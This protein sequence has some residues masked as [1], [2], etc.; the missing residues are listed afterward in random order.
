MTISCNAKR[1]IITG[2]SG[3]VGA[4]LARRLVHDGHEVHLFVRKG[5]TPWRIDALRAEARFTEVDLSDADGLIRVVADIR[6]DWVFHLAAYGAYPDQ[7]DL[8]RMVDTNIVGTMNLVAACLKTGF[9][10]FIN[11][12]SSSEYGFKTHAPSETEWLEPNSHYAVTKASATVFCSYTAQRYGVQLPTLRLYSVY[13]P[14]EEPT[15]LIPTIIVKGLRGELPPLTNPD[16][17][18]DYVYVEDVIDAFLLAAT[19][20]IREPGAVYNVGTGIQTSLREVVD[21]AR[22]AMGITAE[23]QWGTM[24]NR[25]WD[26]SIWVADN[27]KIQAELGWRPHHSFEHAFQMTADWFRDTPGLR[28]FY[29]HRSY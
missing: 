24:A 25:S 10:A 23:P 6:P 19:Q 3:F 18:R 9:Q 28:D 16:I 7:T 29:E 14:Y 26:T 11:T 2:G 5:Y 27:R 17:A 20:A 22:S 1:V 12:G 4:N 15:R 8:R 21:V 13:G